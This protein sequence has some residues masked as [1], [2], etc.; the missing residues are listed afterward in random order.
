MSTIIIK[1][2]TLLNF[3]G[4]RNLE[5]NFRHTGNT[6]KGANGTGKTTVFDAFTWLLFGKDSKGRSDFDIKTLYINGK[7]IPR[8]SHEVSAVLLID[9]QP[10]KLRKVFTEKW[11]RHRGSTEDSFEG[12]KTEQYWDD[13]PLSESEYSSRVDAVCAEDTFRLITNPAHF[14]SL[15]KDEQRQ[16]LFKLAGDVTDEDVAATSK[17]LSDF[18]RMLSGKSVKDFR[19]EISA[20]KKIIKQDI[21]NIPARIDEVQRAMPEQQDWTAIEKELSDKKKALQDIDTQILSVARSFEAVSKHS[22]QVA[23]TIAQLKS[24]RLQRESALYDAQLKTY[25]EEQ[26]KYYKYDTEIRNLESNKGQ[27]EH[28]LE[29]MQPRKD[30]LLK[31]REELIAEWH[32]LKESTPDF[33]KIQTECPLCHTPFN[34]YDIESKRKELEEHFNVELSNRLQKNSEQG[35]DIKAQLAAIEERGSQI[36]KDIDDLSTKISE[37]KKN[38]VPQPTAPEC[39]HA[40]RDARMIAIDNQLFELQ[41]EL[42]QEPSAPDTVE[43]Q[44]GKLV[45]SESIQELQSTLSLRDRIKEGEKRIKELRDELRSQS[46]ELARLEGLEYQSDEFVKAKAEMVESRINSMFKYVHFKMYDTQVNGARVETCEATHNGVPY[47]I[48]NTASR[49]N[50]GLDIINA[51][52]AHYNVHAPI[53]IDNRESV[54]YIIPTSAQ[55]I[56]L[57]V[58][59]SSINLQI[60]EN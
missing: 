5:L 7:A 33:S 53:F 1:Q 2:L 32:T 8:I 41:K 46:E 48:D 10:S 55:I 20:K 42:Q 35:H 31:R 3:K 44:H 11:T 60:T 45:L 26:E 21:A 14:C 43:L 16:T 52:S 36:S 59:P 15:K 51:I 9:G 30:D 56:N 28:A 50:C 19:A 22:E 12:H 4:A 29:A 39:K 25:H 38:P 18:V 40:V 34:A 37:L 13:V 6:I 24:E 54:T 58:D 27:L 17:D 49:L 47:N 57:C 23:Q